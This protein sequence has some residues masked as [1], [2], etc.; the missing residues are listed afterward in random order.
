MALGGGGAHTSPSPRQAASW[1]RPGQRPVQAARE[2]K[3]KDLVLFT[4]KQSRGME[5]K[6]SGRERDKEGGGISVSIPV[7][8]QTTAACPPPNHRRGDPCC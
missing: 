8:P 2:Q 6:D 3:A 1:N 5:V 4:H 7:P